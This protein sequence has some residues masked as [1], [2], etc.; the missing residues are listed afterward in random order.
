[1]HI[2][3]YPLVAESNPPHLTAS[4]GGVSSMLI[5][6]GGFILPLFGWCMSLMGDVRLVGH[7]HVYSLMDYRIGMAVLPIAYILAG[8]AAYC[9]KDTIQ[10]S[11]ISIEE[12]S[13]ESEREVIDGASNVVEEAF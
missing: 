12:A 4:A 3:G 6:A 1:M 7:A 13:A 2:V 11:A 9:V 10:V 8:W 5:M